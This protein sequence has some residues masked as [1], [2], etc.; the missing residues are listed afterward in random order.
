MPADC[1]VLALEAAVGA[2]GVLEQEWTHAAQTAIDADGEYA[3][4]LCDYWLR[5]WEALTSAAQG[6]TGASGQGSGRGDRLALVCMQ[7]DLERA[8]D[9]AFVD[10][11]HWR[12]VQ[13]IYELQRRPLPCRTGQA[14]EPAMSACAWWLAMSRIAAQLGWRGY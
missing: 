8:T 10:R 14:Q 5:N 6:G 11:W 13:R 1:T 7:A 3:P 12:S 9:L 2:L 4:E